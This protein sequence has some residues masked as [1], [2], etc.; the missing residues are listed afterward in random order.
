[1][2]SPGALRY[3]GIFGRLTCF[4]VCKNS[5]TFHPLMMRRGI[6]SYFPSVTAVV[7]LKICFERNCLR[8]R[9]L[10]GLRE[11]LQR[12]TTTQTPIEVSVF[13]RLAQFNAGWMQTEGGFEFVSSQ[14][15][16]R[17]KMRPGFEDQRRCVGGSRQP[18]PSEGAEVSGRFCRLS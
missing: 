7:G 18:G 4:H 1:M 3:F 13:Q 5:Q 8:E 2:R 12:S 11:L 16:A 10:P 6:I 14:L 15:G 9:V 17:C